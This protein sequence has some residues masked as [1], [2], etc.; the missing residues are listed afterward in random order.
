MELAGAPGRSTMKP[1]DRP[2]FLVGL[3]LLDRRSSYI[4]GPGAWRSAESGGM[5]LESLAFFLGARSYDKSLAG[6]G[7]CSSFGCRRAATHVGNRLALSPRLSRL[8]LGRE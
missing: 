5:V 3:R 4:R 1:H 8:L 2:I 7:D 6:T